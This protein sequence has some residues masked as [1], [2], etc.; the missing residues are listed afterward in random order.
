MG[1]HGIEGGVELGIVD[2]EANEGLHAVAGQVEQAGVV[3]AL[4]GA[5]GNPDYRLVH[6]IE[7]VPG[8]FHVGG[9]AVVD[10]AHARPLAYH[11]QAVVGVLE[12]GQTGFNFFGS[13]AGHAGGEHGGQ[14]ILAVVL[15][16]ER[17]VG[18][19]HFLAAVFV[20]AGA[21]VGAQHVLGGEVARQVHIVPVVQTER[22][23]ARF[24]ESRLEIAVR[25]LIVGIIDESTVAGQV[26]GDAQL[27]LRVGFQRVVVAVKMVGRDVEQNG[28]PRLK[29]VSVIELKAA[30]LH[31]VIVVLV[32]NHLLGE[33]EAHIAGQAHF[34]SGAFQQVV[35][36]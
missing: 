36:E 23:L 27:G 25:Y 17:R 29:T 2:A 6:A 4:V 19:A 10:E 22:Q 20:D 3:V 35:N 33:A 12:R 9:L 13:Q 24:E 1:Y 28:N 21:E 5:A 30:Q 34:E 7:R 11:L 26:A 31:Y 32:G 14:G 8:R 18:G 15:A 16:D